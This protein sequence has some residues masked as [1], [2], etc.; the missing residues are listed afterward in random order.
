MSKTPL[1]LVEDSWDG[2]QRA[3]EILGNDFE[4]QRVSAP[5]EAL[6]LLEQMQAD[7]KE[8]P[9]VVLTNLTLD[10]RLAARRD[11]IRHV[12]RAMPRCIIVVW[13]NHSVT[14]Q[15]RARELGADLVYAK[16]WDDAA[17][18]AGI[19]RVRA[20]SADFVPAN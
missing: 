10:G 18:A 4:I 17:M 3:Q 12:R 2:I 7:G 9:E 20:C 8:L 6:I 14:A 16:Y 13:I 11:F 19:Q 5:W 15:V 1:L